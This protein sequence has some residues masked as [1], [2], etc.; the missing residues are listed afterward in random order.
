MEDVQWDKEQAAI[1]GMSE[2]EEENMDDIE[3]EDVEIE[4]V[5]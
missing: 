4:P 5:K 2:G 1:A 3:I